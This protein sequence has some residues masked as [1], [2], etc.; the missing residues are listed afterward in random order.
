MSSFLHTRERK[1]VKLCEV[2]CGSWTKKPL[3]I[4]DWTF[5]G[6]WVIEHWSFFPLALVFAQS[7]RFE[8]AAHHWA[9]LGPA[10]RFGKTSLAKG[11][12]QSRVGKHVRHSSL[13]RV[14]FV[15]PI[16]RAAIATTCT[17]NLRTRRS[18]R[19]NFPNPASVQR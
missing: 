4:A 1:Q 7:H 16:R 18:C 11:G 10:R 13:I 17:N 19:T 14:P 12:Q 15:L 8:N 3:L 5:F 2:S 6:H 9:G